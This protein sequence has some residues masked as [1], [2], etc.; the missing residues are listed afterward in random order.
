MQA[1]AGHALGADNEES[2]LR[3]DP[4][5]REAIRCFNA[6]D[7]YPCHDQ[8]EALWHETQGPLRPV[9][10]GLLQIAVAQLHLERHNLHGA[11][12]LLGEGLGRLR[13]GPD[14]ALELD[15][16]HVRAQAAERLQRLQQNSSLDD[17]SA[18]ELRAMRPASSVH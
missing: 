11:T 13:Q 17:C 16:E 14:Q 4:R 5:L 3:R 15:L 10:Q 2:R 18:L 12:V 8:F 6:G 9:L 1:A 7:W